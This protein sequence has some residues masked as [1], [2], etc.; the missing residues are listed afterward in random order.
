MQ[1]SFSGDSIRRNRLAG[2]IAAAMALLFAVAGC[3][4]DKTPTAK[5]GTNSGTTEGTNSGTAGTAKIAD[6]L[7]PINVAYLGLT[8]EAPI[9]AAY[10]KGFFKEEGLEPTLIKTDWD[11]SVR[12]LAWVSSM[13]T[14]R[15]SCSCSS[16]SSRGST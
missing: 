8:C 15:S 16:Q 6:G 14:I 4:K 10:E 13:P 1:T 11:G 5:T 7:I 3:N 12:G 2:G 9:F